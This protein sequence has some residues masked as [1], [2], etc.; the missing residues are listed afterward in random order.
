MNSFFYIVV[1]LQ[2][3][4]AFKQIK[5]DIFVWLE[6]ALKVIIKI[7]VQEIFFISYSG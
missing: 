4:M 2:I 3:C 6:V 5:K 1:I 7:L